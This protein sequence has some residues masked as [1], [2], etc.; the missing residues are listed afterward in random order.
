MSDNQT[1]SD[2]LDKIAKIRA[3]AERGGTLHEA[4]V[5]AAKMHELLIRHNLTL[6]DVQHHAER[7]ARTVERQDYLYGPHRWKGEL[8]SV[9][10]KHNMCRFIYQTW[11]KGFTV[12]GHAH[13]LI[14]VEQMYL[15]LVEEI[16]R[17]A[18][19]ERDRLK[20]APYQRRNPAYIS[21]SD[22]ETYD[23]DQ[24]AVRTAREIHTHNTAKYDAE[25]R[26][27]AFRHAFRLGAVA[28]IHE[29]LRKSRKALQEATPAAQWAIVPVLEAEVAAYYDELFPNRSNVRGSRSSSGAAY[30][31]G[32]AAGSGIN[33]SRQ[34]GGGRNT[35]AL[36]R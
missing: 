26:W 21:R 22:F 9:L 14:I 35:P 1:L 7:T 20:A 12:V 10:A 6:D 27:S 17:L 18:R 31:L 25:E 33:L 5:A 28:G 23:D 3:L 19:I 32:R 4:E 13:N 15:W 36:G 29:A 11:K 24:D 2:I 34:M 16:D 8:A 30:G